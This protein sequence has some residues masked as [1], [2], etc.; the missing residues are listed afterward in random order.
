MFDDICV[1]VKPAIKANKQPH[2]A[3]PVLI[4]THRPYFFSGQNSDEKSVKNFPARA[5]LAYIHSF[6]IVSIYKICVVQFPYTS[7]IQSLETNITKCRTRT[8]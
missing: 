1:S 5:M 4:D 7:D 3:S 6:Y 2:V 8:L